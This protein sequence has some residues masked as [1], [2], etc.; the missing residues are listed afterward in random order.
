MYIR[1]VSLIVLV[2]C[3]LDEFAIC[4]AVVTD[5]VLNKIVWVF[6]N[7]FCLLKY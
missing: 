6:L 7:M 5:F 2:N 4:F 3:L 1:V